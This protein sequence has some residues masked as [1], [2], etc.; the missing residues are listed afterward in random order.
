MTIRNKSWRDD[1]IRPELPIRKFSNRLI[2]LVEEGTLSAVEVVRMCV[3]Y[4]SE[5]DVEDMCNCNE[6][7]DVMFEEPDE[8]DEEA[9]EDSEIE[10]ST[11]PTESTGANF[12]TGTSEPSMCQPPELDDDTES[13]DDPEDK[14]YRIS[15]SAKLSPNDL[16]AMNKCFFDALNESMNIYDL[17]DLV[18]EEDK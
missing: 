10:N 18:I 5:D 8:E 2:E 12:G 3:K 11:G 4:M 7:T 14:W 17:A 15:F 6:L 9:D 1:L 16:R 13:Y